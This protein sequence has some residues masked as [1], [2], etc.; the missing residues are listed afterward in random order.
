M[1][2]Q[3]SDTKGEERNECVNERVVNIAEIGYSL[4][5]FLQDQGPPLVS[6]YNNTG[7]GGGDRRTF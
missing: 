6:L 3:G 2:V 5:H 7:G 1:N 4:R